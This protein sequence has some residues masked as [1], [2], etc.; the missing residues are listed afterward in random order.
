L[1]VPVPTWQ[2]LNT[3]S[4]ADWNGR[5]LTQTR[6]MP[7]TDSLGLARRPGGGRGPS[8]TARP[9]SDAH[10]QGACAA[11]TRSRDARRGGGGAGSSSGPLV[12]ILWVG[13]AES[14]CSGGRAAAKP[15]NASRPTAAAA[16][17]GSTGRWPRLEV[18]T[19]TAPGRGR[20]QPP[21]AGLRVL[22][23]PRPGDAAPPGAVTSVTRTRTARA[24]SP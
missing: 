19:L 4:Q 23:E 22:S 18:Q 13:G 15:G 24:R 16:P 21:A 12:I 8:Q 20:F 9:K 6:L 3:P 14:A 2:T 10:R 1:Q 7:D 17:G 11:P 5:T